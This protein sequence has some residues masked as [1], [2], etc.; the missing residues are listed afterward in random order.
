MTTYGNTVL[1]ANENIPIAVRPSSI[2]RGK[3]RKIVKSETNARRLGLWNFGVKNIGVHPSLLVP[4][5][6]DPVEAAAYYHSIYTAQVEY[7]LEIDELL[8]T[9]TADHTYSVT[10]GNSPLTQSFVNDKRLPPNKNVYFIS[11]ENNMIAGGSTVTFLGTTYGAGD[12]N[13]PS[14]IATA[15]YIPR[16]PYLLVN[17]NSFQAASEPAWTNLPTNNVAFIRRTDALGNIPDMNQKFSIPEF[18]ID[19]AYLDN[20]VTG[21]TFHVYEIKD[22]YDCGEHYRFFQ[23]K[24]QAWTDNEWDTEVAT[25]A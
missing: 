23:R 1:Q 16:N 17:R 15:Y 11:S 22:R 20:Y 10:G 13:H 21:F 3:D 8:L 25:D 14:G 6:T 18:G 2:M 4:P 24:Y 9:V 19:R 12:V 5:I 7:H